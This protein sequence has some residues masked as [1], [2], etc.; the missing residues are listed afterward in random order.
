MANLRSRQAVPDSPDTDLD[1][2]MG[3]DALELAYP[4]DEVRVPRLHV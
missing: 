4:D 2:D 1:D 3:L